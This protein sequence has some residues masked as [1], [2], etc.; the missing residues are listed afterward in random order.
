MPLNCKKKKYIYIYS[1]RPLVLVFTVGRKLDFHSQNYLQNL[2]F[3]YNK[4][5]RMM[6]LSSVVIPDDLGTFCGKIFVT[7]HTRMLIAQTCPININL[8]F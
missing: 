2:L 5:V 8:T 6:F 7:R 1:T 3:A 4:L